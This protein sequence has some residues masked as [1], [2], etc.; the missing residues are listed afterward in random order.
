MELKDIKH[1]ELKHW[2]EEMALMCQP[3]K[4]VIIDGS[5]E[6]R[7]KLIKQALAT[8]ELI[9]LDQQRY[10]GC[11]YHRSDPGDVARTEHLTSICTPDRDQAGPT[12][13][14][15]APAEAYDKAKEIL[16]GSM[17]GRT[18]YVIPFSMGPIGSPYAKIGV[19]LTDSLYVVLNMLIMTRAGKKVLAVLGYKG[20]FCKCLHGL[21]DRDPERRL[22]LHFPQDN[23]IWSVGSGYGGNALLGKKC[24]ALRIASYQARQEG[25][26]AEH[27]LI[28]GV[29][30]QDGR[31]FYLAA[32]FPSA[33]GKTNLAMLIPPET[34]RQKGYR[35]WTIGDDIAWLHIN[36]DG[37]LWG[38]NPEAGMF[39]VA[40]G[41]NSQSNPTAMATIA[42]NAIFTN[43]L[44]TEKNGAWWEGGD[45]NPPEQGINWQ[46]NSWHPG[47][48]DGAGKPVLAAHPNSRFTAPIA[49]CPCISSRIE[50]PQ[51]VPIS[52]IIFG[53][54]REKVMP[55]VCQTFNWE[56]GVYTGATLASEVTAAQ[57]RGQGQLRFDPMAMLPFC[58]YNMADY[59]THWLRLGKKISQPPQIFHV[60]WFRKGPDGEFLWPGY[61]ENLRA[62]EWIIKRCRNQVG[63]VETPIGFLPQSTDLDLTGLDI[64]PDALQQLLT[65]NKEEWLQ[66]L[67][68]REKFLGTLGNTMPVG[69]FLQ[70]LMVKERITKM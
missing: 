47:L 1:R 28:M 67:A 35:I 17:E 55:L 12:N 11:Y 48:T 60:N 51:G 41:T 34:L 50:H 29:E 3:D 66:E 22:I 54:R 70:H 6:Q 18:M 20:E 14:W 49:Q 16:A 37:Q 69:I 43:V 63:A 31:I 56:H 23:T 33:C 62:L 15:M 10:P 65:I 39:G 64:S 4:I 13:N 53:G 38:I 8:G 57:E 45:G 25:W 32:A 24:L 40:P 68:A 52:A 58:G 21:A 44:L 26:L 9:E 19:Q 5:P 27:M 61:G 59:L 36:T 30:T 46:G 7:E 42:Q 2:I